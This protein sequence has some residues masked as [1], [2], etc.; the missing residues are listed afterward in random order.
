M[1]MILIQLHIASELI[2][3]G[4]QKP[5]ILVELHLDNLVNTNYNLSHF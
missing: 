5:T 1:R 3:N 2:V 4:I